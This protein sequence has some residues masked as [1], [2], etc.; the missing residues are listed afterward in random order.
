M[1]LK[2]LFETLIKPYKRVIDFQIICDDN[3]ILET[4]QD[5]LVTVFNNLVQNSIEAMQKNMVE[6][7][8]KVIIEVKKMDDFVELSFHDNAGGIAN[9]KI[10][11]IFE[12]YFSTKEEKHGVGLGLYIVKSIIEMHLK[13]TVEVSS[14]ENETTI[15]I[16]LP[17]II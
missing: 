1:G 7:N 11:K 4:Y 9:D 17:I 8:K 5:R 2:K 16:K 12:P 14:I 13:G 15:K 10:S 6:D 3:L